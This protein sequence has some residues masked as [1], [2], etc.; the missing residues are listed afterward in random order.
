MLTMFSAVKSARRTT[1]T[2]IDDETLGL[3]DIDLVVKRGRAL[4]RGVVAAA[5]TIRNSLVFFIPRSCLTQ[6]CYVKTSNLSF[7]A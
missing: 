6:R 2:R 3:D 1:I 4:Y 7:V 5:D